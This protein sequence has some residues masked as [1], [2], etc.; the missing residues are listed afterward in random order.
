MNK[1]KPM[2]WKRLPAGLLMLVFLTSNAGCDFNE[3]KFGPYELRIELFNLGE[4]NELEAVKE[5]EFLVHVD[6]I[7]DDPGVKRRPQQTFRE[8]N[9]VFDGTL[10]RPLTFSA[11]TLRLSLVKLS[12]SDNIG[13]RLHIKTDTETFEREVM[14]FV[15]TE[16]FSHTY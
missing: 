4:F 6:R 5:V 7:T 10:S 15:E 9:F 13:V 12:A 3:E 11:S 2:M 8:T 1:I 14:I 16:H